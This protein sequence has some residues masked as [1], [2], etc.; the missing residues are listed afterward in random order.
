MNAHVVSSI[1]LVFDIVGAAWVVKGVIAG[2]DDELA[3]A[4][5]TSA[6]WA[7]GPAPTPRRALLKLLRDARRDARVGAV[8]LVLGFAGQLASQ[9]IPT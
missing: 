1:G 3:A 7:G 8:F 4:A 9:W 6:T 5:D 2:R